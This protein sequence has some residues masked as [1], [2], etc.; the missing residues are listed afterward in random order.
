MRESERNKSP[1][2][3]VVGAQMKR[4]Q[5]T[6][7]LFAFCALLWPAGPAFAQ[8]VT[9]GALAGTVVNA[10][11]APVDGASVIA[12][13]LPS[14]TTYEGTSRADGRFQIIG[15]RVGGPYSVT[16]AHAGAGN[17]F[18]PQT[19]D[20]VTVNLG[21]STDLEFKVTPITLTESVTVTGT[22]DP[23]FASDRTGA[24]TQISR[25]ELQTLPSVGNRLESIT[26]L[27]PQSGGN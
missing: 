15:M 10:D 9:T 6:L 3:L 20:D 7:I 5:R 19:K 2:Q 21:V 23:V 12:I 24:A 25:Q 13:H 27:T 11:G 1:I 26:R 16:V 4:M 8:G 18:E 17:A 22:V 14:G